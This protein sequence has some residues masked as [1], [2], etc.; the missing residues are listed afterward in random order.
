MLM[1]A[2]VACTLVLTAGILQANSKNVAGLTISHL[3]FIALI[4]GGAMLTGGMIWR[5]L[6]QARSER[7]AALRENAVLK[8]KLQTAESVMSAEPQSLIYWEKGTH[9]NVVSHSLSGIAGLPEEAERLLRFGTWLDPRS[10]KTLKSALDALLREGRPFN[11]ILKTREGGHVESDGRAAAGRAVLRLR[12]IAGYKRDISKIIDEHQNLARDIRSSR[13]LLNALPMPVWLKDGEG[14]MTWVNAAYVSAVEG[15]SADEVISRQVELL[16]QRQREAVGRA[17]ATMHSYRRKI[18]LITGGERRAYDVIVIQ[19]EDSSTG[20]AIDVAAL[21][22]AQGEL[23]RQ[24]AAFDRTLDRVATAVIIFNS[25]RKLVFFNDAYQALWQLDAAWLNAGPKDGDV[26]DR[27]RELGKLPEVVNYRDWRGQVLSA[28]E[29][30]REHEDWWHL[31]DGRIL[32]V[33]IEQRADGGVTHLYVDETERLGLESR[34]NAMIR[35]QRE[36]LDSLKEGVAVL[37][38]DGRLKLHNSAFAQIWQLSPQRLSEHPHVDEIIAE[39]RKL[40]NDS[41]TWSRL[42]QVVTAFSAERTPEEGQMVWADNT[43]IDFATTPLPDGAT[44]LTFADVTDS[45]RYE[46]AL[47]ERNEALIASDK[48]KNQFIG[49][50]SYELRAPLTN[51]IGFSELLESPRVG[52]LNAKQHEYLSDIT[53]SSKTLLAIIDDILDLATIDAGALEL[54]TERIGVR[55][56]VE[57]ALAGIR[58]RAVRADLVLDIAIADEA[59]TFIADPSRVRQVLYNL[60]SNAVGFSKPGGTVLLTCWREGGFMVFQVEDHGVGIAKEDQEHVFE[61]FESRSQGSSHRGAGLGLSIVKSLVELHRGTMVL[62]SEPGIGTRVTVRLPEN[63]PPAELFE[64][65]TGPGTRPRA[66]SSPLDRP[67]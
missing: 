38:T 56:T 26:L 60:M 3:L 6:A 63:G 42:K 15:A 14:R 35:V 21:E 55:E 43:V 44:L 16:E 62:E 28:S 30:G 37:A 52:P 17:L 58:E 54:K 59:T 33:I 65:A 48:L 51:I 27:L 9:L 13:S 8:Q 53:F 19:L 7:L 36:T 57:E 23:D 32:H 5:A 2:S 46:R 12:D 64:T 47:V 39:A 22:T 31:P 1:A 20:A 11:L 24:I 45:K 66:V 34:F 67:D 18:H 61:R 41:A 10:A 40:Y 49:H 25:D 29:G 4:A 50:V